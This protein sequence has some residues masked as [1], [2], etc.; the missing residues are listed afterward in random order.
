MD[1]I[2]YEIFKDLRYEIFKDLLNILLAVAAVVAAVAS[3]LIYKSLLYVIGRKVTLA[4]EI[5]LDKAL[6]GYH[7]TSGY[8]YWRDYDEH[9]ECLFSMD[10]G[11]LEKRWNKEIFQ[12]GLM[13]EFK[14]KGISLS[15][16]ITV[17]E[18]EEEDK[19]VIA[20]KEK[21]NIF[22]VRKEDG[23][24]NIYKKDL[25]K[26]DQAIKATKQGYD[27]YAT[28]LEKRDP[29]SDSEW[30]ICWIKNNLAYYYAEKQR[31]ERTT[32]GEK[33]LAQRFVKYL[34]DR[35]DKCPKKREER[36]AWVDTRL[37]VRKRF[38]LE[39]INSL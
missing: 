19:W 27:D 34:W 35:I 18:E 23:T 8:D 6:L 1:A 28:K 14:N 3:A 5:Q 15:D 25:W 12:D 24:L 39:D 10:D 11:V 26:L 31:L 9:S 13:K 2:I 20:D 30:L 21:E 32:P 37:F 36:D 22:I 4:T 33:A 29:D 17:T 38:F 7:I 16:N